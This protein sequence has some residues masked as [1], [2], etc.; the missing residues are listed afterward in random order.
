MEK[1]A[2]DEVSQVGGRNGSEKDTSSERDMLTYVCRLRNEYVDVDNGVALWRC[3]TMRGERA[4][5]KR[6]G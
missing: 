4:A 2:G 1:G 6:R 3:C 5:K